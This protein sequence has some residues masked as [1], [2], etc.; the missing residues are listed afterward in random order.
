MILENVNTYALGL[1]SELVVGSEQSARILA[2]YQVIDRAQ[3]E[4]YQAGLDEGMRAA[5]DAIDA[6]FD[7]GWDHGEAHSDAYDTGYLDGVKDARVAPEHADE[8]VADIVAEAAAHAINGELE[9][10]QD[11]P[12]TM[13]QFLN[14]SDLEAARARAEYDPSNVCDSGDEQ[15]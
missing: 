10:E 11:A 9:A 5:E 2:V 8:V 12:F 6:A 3:H 13:S 4:A 15:P 14:Q 1:A 7:N